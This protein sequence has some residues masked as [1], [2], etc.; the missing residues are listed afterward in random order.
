MNK[1]RRNNNELNAGS[2]VVGDDSFDEDIDE[3]SIMGCKARS[4][5]PDADSTHG[6][7]RGLLVNL[8]AGTGEEDACDAAVVK[9]DDDDGTVQS[10]GGC[11]HQRRSVSTRR[12]I[13]YWWT[14]FASR[15]SR[16]ASSLLNQHTPNLNDILEV[17]GAHP[18][19][20]RRPPRGR[21]MPRDD[22]TPENRID[23]DDEDDDDDDESG[24]DRV[25]FALRE[26]IAM[27]KER[28][29][30]LEYERDGAG[31]D[32]PP[33]RDVV[34]RDAHSTAGGI[35]DIPSVAPVRNLRPDQIS[36]YSRQ[37]LLGDGFGVAGQR[38][39]LS[40]SVLVI[41]AGGIGST[42]LLYLAAAGIGHV[43]VVDYDRVETS[44]LHRQVIHRDVDASGDI[45]R[46]GG[47]N[48]AISARRA[49]LNLNPTMSCTALAI[50]ISADNALEL[51]S[52][53]DVVVDASDNPQT[54]YSL[55][56]ACIL[57]G[58]PLVSGSAMGTEGQLTVYNYQPAD[59]SSDGA[60]QRT[61]CY[62]CLYPKPVAAEGCKSCSDNGVLGMVPGVV[63][64]LQAVEVIKVVTGIGSIM[65]DRLM[66]YDSLHCSFMNVKKPPART[67][68]AVCSPD[69]T[70]KTMSDSE[71]S[72][73]NVR[74]PNIC[75][76]PTS[77]VMLASEQNV[78]CVEY[79]HLR[80][81]GQPHVLL[82]VRVAR[83]YEMC[84]LDGSINLPLE[85]L[86]SQLETVG[87]MSK[88]E[89]PV[90]CICRR[91]IASAEA[92]AIIQKSIEEGNAVHSVYNIAGGLNSWVDT[93]DSEFPQ[94]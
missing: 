28:I 39:L 65:H 76:L 75:A 90:F 53:H 52:K 21:G 22:R 32:Q 14:N 64:I 35:D 72:L 63:G 86:E 77:G 81:N 85:L 57:A 82:D 48:K 20:A 83:Q 41:G 87:L 68:C 89:L 10:H 94:Y 60:I 78:S 88:G 56:D 9:D 50:V 66:M 59:A 7:G 71:K 54:R 16:S 55:N 36:R 93:V 8:M 67:N 38:T 5:V 24:G 12:K 58:K 23:D 62:R 70:I 25:A 42:V 51:V 44:N 34:V 79:N 61:A 17:T 43:T 6:I 92:T 18:L 40:T 80:K 37:L 19:E 47:L 49:M 91:G 84:S 1:R 2:A 11:D 4:S 27:L 13:S 30:A 31:Q 15:V 73:E 45:G 29:R 69:A 3:S 26:E 74:G 33:R 46:E